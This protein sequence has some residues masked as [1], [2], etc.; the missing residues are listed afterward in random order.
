MLPASVLAG[1]LGLLLGPRVLGVLPF[2]D[3][4][5]TYASVLIAVVFGCLG[6]TD[7]PR[8]H[9]FGRSTAAF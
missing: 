9:G 2:S 6:L 1:F 4:L 5:G 3:Q 8:G 7:T